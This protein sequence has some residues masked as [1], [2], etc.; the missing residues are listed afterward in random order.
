MHTDV[1]FV[2]LSSTKRDLNYTPL[3]H[4]EREIYRF[5]VQLLQE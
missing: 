2:L 5:L 1:S 3:L 4:I